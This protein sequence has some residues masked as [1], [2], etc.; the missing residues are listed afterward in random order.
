MDVKYRRVK[1]ESTPMSMSASISSKQKRQ[2]TDWGWLIGKTKR[3]E[4]FYWKV[5]PGH[6]ATDSEMLKNDN[7]LKNLTLFTSEQLNLSDDTVA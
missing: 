2:T 5:C 3:K 7:W 6:Y 4:P 1:W